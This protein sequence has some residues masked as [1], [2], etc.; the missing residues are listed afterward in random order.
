VVAKALND[1]LE[2][3]KIKVKKLCGGDSHSL[4]LSNDGE[5]Y[6]W[7]NNSF[8]QSGQ[9]EDH[10]IKEP[11]KID[12][13]ENIVDIGAWGNYSIAINETGDVYGF[14]ELRDITG[15]DNE[16]S[17]VRICGASSKNKPAKVSCG[18]SHILIFSQ[19]EK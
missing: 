4:L 2:A 3:N 15:A 19:K 13:L 7:G 12:G 16:F 10:L 18:K 9:G 1:L 11:R 8:G 17:P 6:S 14:G 5:L